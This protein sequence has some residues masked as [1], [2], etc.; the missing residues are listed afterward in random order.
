MFI[1]AATVVFALGWAMPRDFAKAAESICSDGKAC[2]YCRE[3]SLP[4]VDVGGGKIVE[5]AASQL[6]QT[7]LQCRG[8]DGVSVTFAG[9]IEDAEKT[10]LRFCL[11][12]VS[13]QSWEGLT[14]I[15]GFSAKLR[16]GVV[17]DGKKINL[18]IAYPNGE[19]TVGSPLILGSY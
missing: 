18:Q 8:V 1:L 16:G 12:S 7:L 3:T 15:C 2:V 6:R 17:A 4:Y 10:A 9:T 5:C 19:V 14:V 13:R 11:S